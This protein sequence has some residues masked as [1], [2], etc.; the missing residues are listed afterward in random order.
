MRNYD[1]EA[2]MLSLFENI[3]EE[4]THD[5]KRVGKHRSYDRTEEAE[6][7]INQ[8]LRNVSAELPTYTYENY[9]QG[10]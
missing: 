5:D 1:S 10:P 9:Y 3:T 8:D 4:R 6:K 7:N 2:Y